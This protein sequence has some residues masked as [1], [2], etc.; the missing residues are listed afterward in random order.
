MISPLKLANTPTPFYRLSRISELWNG[1]IWI[2]RDDLSG[3]G[4]SGNKVRKLE[5]LLADAIDK[6]ADTIITCGGVQSNHCRAT[7]LASVRIGLKCTLLLRG[8]KPAVIDGNL[9]FDMLSGADIHFISEDRYNSNL[10]QELNNLAS[11]VNVS[12][13][14]AY[15]IPEG[16]S[17][18]VGAWGYVQALSE[19][20]QQ[21]FEQNVKPNRIICA[22]GSGG[23]HAGLLSGA[24]IENWDV[25]IVS[26][27]VGYDREETVN[28]IMEIINGMIDIYKLNIRIRKSDIKVIEG[29]LG[30]GYAK[31]GNEVIDVISEM[32]RNEGVIVDPVYAGKAATAIKYETAK[33]MMKGTTVFWHTGGI[34]GLFPFKNRFK[35]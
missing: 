14:K 11:E 1:N 16:G 23:T 32:A 9:L 17:N 29:Y 20:R 31:A 21:C 24:L 3:T 5:Y 35:Y 15:I 33:G 13:G 4:L 26:V 28:R 6:K 8:E 7:A 30:E 12:K 27:T 10:D 34:F 18:P 25:D 2:K 22:T 19:L